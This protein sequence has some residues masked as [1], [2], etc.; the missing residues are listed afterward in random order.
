[1]IDTFRMDAIE[2]PLA[3][4]QCGNADVDKTSMAR[5]LVTEIGDELTTLLKGAAA[6]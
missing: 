6:D 5:S 2:R 1:V 3:F 4:D